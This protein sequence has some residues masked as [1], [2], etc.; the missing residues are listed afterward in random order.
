MHLRSFEKWIVSEVLTDLKRPNQLCLAV[1]ATA[2]P[3]FLYLAPQS[4][5]RTLW[6]GASLPEPYLLCRYHN[7][8]LDAAK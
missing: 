3:P 2:T 4:C 5:P 8:P 6:S 7:L 1:A